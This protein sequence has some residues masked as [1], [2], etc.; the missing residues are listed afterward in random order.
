MWRRQLIYKYSR[1]MKEF[2]I[3]KS[4][5]MS[6]RLNQL[7][8]VVY[9]ETF[10]L[11]ESLPRQEVKVLRENIDMFNFATYEMRDKELRKKILRVQSESPYFGESES[12][13]TNYQSS[14]ASEEEEIEKKAIKRKFMK[15]PR[16]N[17]A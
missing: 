14:T 6:N 16:F 8:N 9:R 1:A 13:W 17:N 4:E 15:C 11:M 12:R 7:M 5:L 3:S 10:L 2:D